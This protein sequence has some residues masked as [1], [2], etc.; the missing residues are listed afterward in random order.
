[1][2]LTYLIGGANLRQPI[3]NASNPR[4][5][6]KTMGAG[7]TFQLTFESGPQKAGRLLPVHVKNSILLSKSSG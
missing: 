4:L 5:I 1:L 7:F 2:R 3:V 6:L